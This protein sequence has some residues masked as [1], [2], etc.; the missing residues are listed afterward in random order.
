MGQT[1][2]KDMKQSIGD[3]ITIFD[4][5]A[6]TLIFR[7]SF[8]DLVNLDDPNYC[9]KLISEASETISKHLTQ[10]EIRIM[11]ERLEKGA[12]PETAANPY[13]DVIEK[14]YFPKKHP[15]CVKIAKFYIT[16]AHV[17]SAITRAVNPIYEY[18]HTNG[19]IIHEVDKSQ[20][21][22]GVKVREVYYNFCMRRLSAVLLH[23]GVNASRKVKLCGLN[24]D[25][26]TL[27]DDL[28][29]QSLEQ[30][31]KNG[32]EYGSIRKGFDYMTKDSRQLYEEAVASLNEKIRGTEESKAT[33]KKFS[34]VK[35]I[36]YREM[37]E[38]AK[39][40]D[41]SLHNE[42][43]FSESEFKEY[44]ALLREML[45]TTMRQQE[46]IA[47]HL[48][49]LCSKKEDGTYDINPELTEETL[50][51]LV[52]DVRTD[53]LNLYLRCQDDFN[54]IKTMLTR[55]AKKKI[56]KTIQERESFLDDVLNTME[57]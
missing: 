25:F 28:G 6:S 54:R 35:Q 41:I 12:N 8:Q 31:F 37:P 9:N 33:P 27:M 18:R 22:E 26:K 2:V 42:L 23:P 38:C 24:D 4:D 10:E 40:S 3:I 44:R 51:E 52:V 53:I 39:D 36:N 32:F 11:A 55:I 21:P 29:I 20:I 50:A 30:L 34:D 49:T 45:D 19:D 56:Q 1:Q 46:K 48:T 13:D 14:K 47:L 5:I 57:L 16:C 43:N 7:P 17:Y 15:Y